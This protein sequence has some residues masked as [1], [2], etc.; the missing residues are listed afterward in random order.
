MSTRTIVRNVLTG[1]STAALLFTASAY[2]QQSL[3]P[4]NLGSAGYYVI[5]SQTGITD[6]P[7]SAVTGNIGTSP[8]TG[9]ADLLTCTEVAGEVFSVDAAGPAPCSR[10]DPSGLTVA[11][12]DM[13]TA[14]TIAAGLPNPKATEVGAGNIGGMTLTPGLYKWGTSVYIPAAVTLSGGPN[15]VFIFQIAQ[16]LTLANGIAVH[17]TGGVQAKNVFWQVS[18]QATFGTTSHMEGIV[19]C[20]S[21]I[22][23]QTGASINGRLYA[24]TAVTLQM[25]AV[26][27]PGSSQRR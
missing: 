24:Q 19:L 1:I 8:I 26:T 9:A 27:E 21:L 20:K 7:K 22:A 23:M 14:Y 6:V 18:G 11:I 17:L 2:A 15:D 13:Q 12:L 4:I 5:L 16:N 3:A 25:N 10:M